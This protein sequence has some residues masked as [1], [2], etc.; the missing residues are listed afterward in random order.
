MELTLP[1]AV[2][3]RSD[4]FKVRQAM[5]CSVAMPAG[6][7][8]T[9]IIAGL[10]AL[11]VEDRERA[12]ILTH[13]HAGVQALR[14]RTRKL[15]IGSSEARIDTIASW[16][17]R[18]IH[19]YPR[20]AGVMVPT[21]PDSSASRSY[22]EGATRVLQ[23]S[24]LQQVLAATYAFAIIDEYQDCTARQHGLAQAVAAA[25]PIAVLGDPLQA[26]FGWDSA[27]PLPSWNGEIQPLWPNVDIDIYPWRWHNQNRRLGHWLLTSLFR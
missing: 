10:A 14:Q 8:K 16:A 17:H 27:D 26:I 5:P 9:E 12:L 13:T 24:A 11:A 6:T 20:L 25:L 15:G 7:G 21:E 22:Y 4:A 18:L 3:T 2:D 1:Y 19:R 23:H